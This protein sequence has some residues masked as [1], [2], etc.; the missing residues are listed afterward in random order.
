MSDAQDLSGEWRGVFNYPAAAGPPTEFAAALRDAGGRLSGTVSEP[1]INGGVVHAIIDGRREGSAVSFSKLYD[2]PDE[3]Y[4][5]V[6]YQGE[7]TGDGLVIS[8][9]WTLPDGWS[10]TFIMVRPGGVEE[11]AEEG[12]EQPVD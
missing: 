3:G 11:E 6:A 4:D 9:R 12:A 10:G 2:R 8:G 5:M 1:S 7:V